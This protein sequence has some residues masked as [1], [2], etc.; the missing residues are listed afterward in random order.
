MP[1]HTLITHICSF[2]TGVVTCVAQLATDFSCFENIG[3]FKGKT[4]LVDM[5]NTLVDWDAEFIHR[6]AVATGRPITE[7]DEMVR[8]RAKFEIEEPQLRGWFFWVCLGRYN[9]G[10]LIKILNL[11]KTHELKRK[12]IFEPNLHAFGFQPLIFQGLLINMRITCPY[13]HHDATKLWRNM[14]LS[15]TFIP[16]GW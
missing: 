13:M 8:K 14:K 15:I 3:I 12:V 9:P 5:D 16:K 4:V 10:K 7:V 1:R 2:Y 6:F 11:N